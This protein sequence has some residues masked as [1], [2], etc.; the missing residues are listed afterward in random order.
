MPIP[1]SLYN[2]IDYQ[3]DLMIKKLDYEQKKKLLEFLKAIESLNK[4]TD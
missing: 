4:S 1:A 2:Q 3:L